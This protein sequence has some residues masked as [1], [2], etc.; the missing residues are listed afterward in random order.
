MHTMLSVVQFVIIN[1]FLFF[2]GLV[3]TAPHHKNTSVVRCGLFY[4]DYGKA[5]NKEQKK[6]RP[7]TA[8]RNFTRAGCK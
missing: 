4:T 3:V 8:V 5:I 2:T 7:H 1:A 6:S